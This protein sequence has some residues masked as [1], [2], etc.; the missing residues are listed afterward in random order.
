MQT[1]TICLTCAHYRQ[2]QEEVY[3]RSRRQKETSKR[4]WR[5]RCRRAGACIDC[6]SASWQNETAAEQHMH[7]NTLSLRGTRAST[8]TPSHT[9]TERESTNIQAR[10]RTDGG[11]ERFRQAWMERQTDRRTDGRT[12]M[13]TNR[14]ADK[15]A[16]KPANTPFQ[17]AKRTKQH[18]QKAIDQTI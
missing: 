10:G 12:D 18:S 17:T 14:E 2:R 6:T 3:N 1:M 7:T 15:P 8:H 4:L 5:R 13:H 9:Q 16:S 11:T